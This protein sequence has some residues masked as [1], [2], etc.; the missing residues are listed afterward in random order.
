MLTRLKITNF[1]LIDELELDLSSG[2]TVLT[3]E[4]GSGKSIIIDALLLLFGA[5]IN[6]DIF[7]H[8]KP[9]ELV[10][11]FI[12]G[13]QD[14]LAWLSNNDLVDDDQPS[15]VICRRV[16]DNNGKNKIYINGHAVTSTQIRTFGEYILDVHTQHAAITLLKTDTQRSLLDEYA[17]ISSKTLTLRG[18]YTQVQELQKKLDASLAHSQELEMRRQF[19][20]EMHTELAALDLHPGEWIELEARHK[21]LTHG[22]IITDELTY[23]QNSL[24]NQDNSVLGALHNLSSHLNKI[25]PYAPKVGEL[26]TTLNTIEI[27]LTEFNRELGSVLHGIITDPQELAQHEARIE[28]IFNLSRKYKIGPEQIVDKMI[29][30]QAEIAALAH[31]SNLDLLKVELAAVTTQY[32]ALAQEITN[33]RKKCAT[34]LSTHVTTML[35][36]LAIT[37]EFH[38]VLQPLNE[39]SAHGMENVE[40]RVAFNKGIAPQPL[41]KVASGGELSRTALTLYLLLSMQNAPEII[42]FD[43]I[44]IGIGGK[45]AAIVGQML[46]QLGNKKQVICITHQPQ[47]ASYGVNH[48]VVNKEHLDETTELSIKYV[49]DNDRINEIARMLGGVHITD[50]TLKHAAEMLNCV[51]PA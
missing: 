5:R 26:L 34:E 10:A 47:T 17:R 39:P 4:T 33:A 28:Q 41:A 43:E 7:R 48:L 9:V 8:D 50:T 24:H 44:D 16:L 2:L 11:E 20:A 13:N 38:I 30:I 42:I 1:V 23:V 37:G 32:D 27:D 14:A 49:S 45:I 51:I 29:E 21:E 31:D 40:Y 12:L 6:G 36:K 46:Q 18:Y 15:N 25:A 35:H 3:G 19:L 22:T